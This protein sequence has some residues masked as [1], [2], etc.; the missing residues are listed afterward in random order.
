MRSFL[1]L[2]VQVYGLFGKSELNS[3]IDKET[4]NVYNDVMQKIEKQS[5]SGSR[6]HIFGNLTHKTGVAVCAKKNSTQCMKVG[7][8]LSVFL[9]LNTGIAFGQKALTEKTATLISTEEYGMVA[10]DATWTMPSGTSGSY[11][12]QPSVQTSGYSYVV[13]I[14]DQTQGTEIKRVGFTQTLPGCNASAETVNLIEG[15]SYLMHVDY[16]I[17][18]DPHLDD[19]PMAKSKIF[20]TCSGS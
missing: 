11:K 2:D 8:L 12:F 1:F 18:G 19:Q 4:L 15:H 14:I 10:T 5:E 3:R 9:A 17:G 7:L 6:P 13:W 20:Y 16:A